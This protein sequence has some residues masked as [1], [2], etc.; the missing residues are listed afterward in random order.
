MLKLFNFMGDYQL[1]F[2]NTIFRL[3]QQI[4]VLAHLSKNKTC[5]LLCKQIIL[6]AMLDKRSVE[7]YLIVQFDV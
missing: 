4:M 6:C 1:D 3:R 7:Y 5:Y 2:I